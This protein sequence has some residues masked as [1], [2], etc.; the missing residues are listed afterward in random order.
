MKAHTKKRTL[1]VRFVAYCRKRFSASKE[2]GLQKGSFSF[3]FLALCL[4]LK[5][6]SYYKEKDSEHN[7]PSSRNT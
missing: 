2:E 5:L 7:V 4:D 3:C 1:E 6:E